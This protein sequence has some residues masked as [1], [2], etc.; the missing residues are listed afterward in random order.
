MPS[1]IRLNRAELEQIVGKIPKFI[2]AFEEMQTV[3]ADVVP[4]QVNLLLKF[5]G[6][7]SVSA[8]AAAGAAD[9]ARKAAES[10]L[11][12]FATL[13]QPVDYSGQIA[14][15]G[16]QIAAIPEPL[17]D[18]FTFYATASEDL[19]SGAFVNVWNNA[20]TPNVR[21]ADADA[22]QQYEVV[23]WTDAGCA[24]GQ[25]AVVRS[26]G[27]NSG[28]SGL[29]T[30]NRYYLSNTVPGGVTATAPATTGELVQVLGIAVSP[31]AIA[32]TYQPATVV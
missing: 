13:P 3:T 21:N 17:P 1:P 32:F 27:I 12:T 26:A 25:T 30:G 11:A 4:D 10:A 23:G 31:S 22:A 19:A 7:A 2:R 16:A 8:E 20:G 6:A 9:D 29:T 24:S 18:A 14:A 5:I 15:L 28:L